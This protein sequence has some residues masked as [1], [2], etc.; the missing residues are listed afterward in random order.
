MRMVAVAAFVVMLL[1]PEAVVGPSFQMS[2]AAVIAI[3]ALHERG[4]GARLPRPARGELDGPHRRGV[5]RCC[6]SPG[7]VIELALMPIVLFHFHRAG[8]YGALANVV[9]IPLM[10]FVTM[11]LIALAL[12][13]DLVGRRRAGVVAGGPIAR[14]AA[15]HRALYRRAAGRGEAACRRW[16]RGPSRCSSPGAVAGA[17]ARPA[18]AVGLVPLLAAIGLLLAT[19]APDVLV[20]GDGRHVGSRARATGCSCCARGGA[21]CARQP[22]RARGHGG[23]ADCARRLA[24]RAVQPGLL[25]R[26]CSTGA[27]G[28]GRC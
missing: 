24:G 15:R 4:P 28:R 9:A 19:P 21:T 25:H 22:A 26:Q 10:T 6:C 3:V 20:S 5:R 27:A 14:P 18:P 7:V 2:F 11:P 13:L 23:R 12:L 16:G 17:V 8:F 1:W